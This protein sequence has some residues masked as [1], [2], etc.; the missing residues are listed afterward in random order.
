MRLSWYAW[1]LSVAT[2]ALSAA[3]AP[4]AHA[5]D[6]A[7]GE[8]LAGECVT[9]HQRSGNSNGIPSIIG[10]P[11]DQFEARLS[12]YLAAIAANAPLTLRAMTR[13]LRELARPEAE[14][15]ADAVDALVADCFDS[16]DYREGQAAF[17]EKRDPVFRGR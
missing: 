17:R 10:W 9:C 8:Y 12:A 16:E 1:R 6:V 4:S 3:L 11:A 13:G 14:Q 5:A 15:D 2:L 7:L